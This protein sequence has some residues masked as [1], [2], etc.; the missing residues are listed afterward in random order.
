MSC[1]YKMKS[2][3]PNIDPCG[4]LQEILYSDSV[5]L[6]TTYCFLFLEIAYKP[7]AGRTTY[8]IALKFIY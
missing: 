6:N 1:I 7:V 4:T 5:L 3:G 8:T 2:S